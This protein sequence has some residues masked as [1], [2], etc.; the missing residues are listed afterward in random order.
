[1]SKLL[2][3]IDALLE[4][5]DEGA[6]IK[7]SAPLFLFLSAEAE[8]ACAEEESEPTK[9]TVLFEEK[10]PVIQT[11]ALRGEMFQIG[12]EGSG[13]TGYDDTPGTTR[14]E[15]LIAGMRD[16]SL[17]PVNFVPP[18]V[19]HATLKHWSDV[20][21]ETDLVIF[22]YETPESHIEHEVDRSKLDK[23]VTMARAN[24]G[25]IEEVV[26]SLRESGI[27]W[28]YA[29][30]GTG[31][32]S[33]TLVISGVRGR[34]A[35]CLQ[36]EELLADVA[37]ALAVIEVNQN[38]NSPAWFKSATESEIPSPLLSIIRGKEP[39]AIVLRTDVPMLNEWAAEQTGWAEF[40]ETPITIR[41]ASREDLYSS[42]EE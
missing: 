10:L 37:A 20:D 40:T 30:G 1:M 35:A 29:A 19:T 17:D 25:T 11:G 18:H 14:Y 22:R 16:N 32:I 4:A 42:A 5:N 9:A 12:S 39:K 38:V 7:S 3:V 2:K 13:I 6:D 21:T 23:L 27:D 33:N 8:R 41:D 31:E 24:P 34:W 28:D 36:T 26:K 15:E